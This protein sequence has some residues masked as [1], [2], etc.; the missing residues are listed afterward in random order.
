VVVEPCGCVGWLASWDVEQVASQLLI[1]SGCTGC[2]RHRNSPQPTLMHLACCIRPCIMVGACA[3]MACRLGYGVWLAALPSHYTDQKF[4]LCAGRC[5]QA[6]RGQHAAQTPAVEAAASRSAEP[7][8]SSWMLRCTAAVR[9]C[10]RPHRRCMPMQLA[11]AA[12]AA[13]M[14]H[15][16]AHWAQAQLAAAVTATGRVAARCHRG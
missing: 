16:T 2:C 5:G 3:G 14:G 11:P 7:T 6:V 8:A 9:H 13:Q 10:S 4:L 12:P 1:C 15:Q